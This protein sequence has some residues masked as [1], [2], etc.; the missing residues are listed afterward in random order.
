MAINDFSSLITLIITIS[1]AYVAVE[2]VKSYTK[3]LC[4][5]IFNYQDDLKKTFDGC[6]NALIDRETLILIKPA[7]INGQGTHTYLEEIKRQHELLQIKIEESE[8]K[9]KNEIVTF[10][11]SKSMP[12]MCFFIFLANVTL[13]FTGVLENVVAVFSQ[14]FAK[15]LSLLSSLYVILGWLW[16]ESSKIQTFFSCLKYS[17]IIYL[18]VVFLSLGYGIIAAFDLFIL[19]PDITLF[20]YVSLLIVVSYGNYIVFMIQIR[21]KFKNF[22]KETD[23]IAKKITEECNSI[24]LKAD[25]LIATNDL[26]DYLQTK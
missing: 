19:F 12:S 13:L 10:C 20:W 1:I 5:R 14:E 2:Y 16:G 24:S 3:T 23:E 26:S 11:I 9:R 21:H 7:N 25:K 6:R 22:K 17:L 18:I 15:A 4:E 8:N